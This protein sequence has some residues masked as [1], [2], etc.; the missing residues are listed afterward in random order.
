MASA[1]SAAPRLVL[2]TLA[3]GPVY[4]GVGTSGATQ[5]VEAFNA[6][7]GTLNLTATA[8]ASWLS[9]TIGASRPCTTRTGTCLPV[10][11]ALNTAALA[12]GDYTETVTLTDPNAVD[13]PRQIL[14]SVGIVGVPASLSF[15]V[16]PSN[17][18]VGSQATTVI[19]PKSQLTTTVTTQTGGK[20][21]ALTTGA[22][23]SVAFGVPYY[24]QASAQTAQAE[25]SYTGSV[26]IAGSTN[27]ADN[28]TMAVTLNVTTSPIVQLL[29]PTQR[30]TAFTDGT[31]PATVVQFSNIGLGKLAITG[32]AATTA[33]GGT[34]F[35]ASVL[36]PDSILI[37]ANPAG[38]KEG[39]YTG[40]A[41]I[42][43]NAANNAQVSVSLTLTV[44]VAGPPVI[45]TGGIVN[46][47]NFA[48]ESASPGEILAVFGDQLAAPGTLVQNTGLPPLATTLGGVQVLVNGVPAPL[49]FAAASQVNFQMPY[50]V[51]ANSVATVQVVSGGKAG[52]TRSINVAAT[53]PR[54]MVWGSNLIAGGYG[55]IV[56][57]LDNSLTLPSTTVVPGFVTKPAKAGDTITIYGIGFGQTTPGAVTG[58]A[59][60]GTN[61]QRV[62]SA[63]VT[64]GGFLAGVSTVVPTS[65]AGLTPSTVGLYQLNVQIPP[66]TPIG[67]AVPVTVTVNGIV[68]NFGYLAVSK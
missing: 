50:E 48:Q 1:L 5:T 30:L 22:S 52:N 44:Q 31:K 68:G 59:A 40:A 34:I 18:G 8:S 28:K 47:A 55:I 41:T 11:I 33:S 54:I 39:L 13:S 53:T 24:V 45:S 19:Y 65:Y 60:S 20:W 26:V 67:A 43:S 37:S 10:N 61:L 38:L 57:A 49:Y 7:D 15:Y 16:T 32:A 66:T 25:G 64:F 29:N 14:V 4:A 51:P 6:G 46:I 42:T 27:P 56:N 36:T 23:G 3:V 12:L 2:S 35:T 21:L 17:G 58:A 9:A 62:A 63:T